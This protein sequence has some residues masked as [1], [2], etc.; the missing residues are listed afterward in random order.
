MK[1]P[2]SVAK[3]GENNEENCTNDQILSKNWVTEANLV[4]SFAF[5]FMGS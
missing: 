5:Y 3:L 2:S 4:L 1:E